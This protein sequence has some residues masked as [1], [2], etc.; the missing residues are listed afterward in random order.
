MIYVDEVQDYLRLPGSLS[1]A[2][3]QARGLGVGLRCASASRPA[4]EV[5]VPGW[6]PMRAR[7]WRSA[8]GQGRPRY[9]RHH[10]RTASSR[11]LHERPPGRST[12]H[13]QLLHQGAGAAGPDGDRESRAPLVRLAEL[14]ADSTTRYG[15]TVVEVDAELIQLVNGTGSGAPRVSRPDRQLLHR[16]QVRR[17]VQF[18][19]RRRTRPRNT[20]K[21]ESS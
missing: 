17:R 6:P 20:S 10:R 5:F 8:V 11:G 4:A 14:A 3:A 15:R 7:G 21:G 13:A 12:P 9:R 2:L 1:D 16:R 18:G 19:R